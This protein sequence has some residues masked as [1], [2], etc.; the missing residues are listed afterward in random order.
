LFVPL[1]LCD[2]VR[3]TPRSA[4]GIELRVSGEAS[5]ADP[6]NLAW[7]AA[8]AF[9]AEPA[10]AGGVELELEKRIP[11]P[12]GLGGGSS[13]AGAVLRGLSRLQPSAVSP[14]RLAELAMGLGADVPFFLDPRP[15][16][17]EGI[18]EQIEP[19][20]GMPILWLALA[21]PGRPLATPDVF[22]GFDADDSLTGSGP[23]PTIRRLLALR[24]SDMRIEG[25]DE[26]DRAGW[27][28][29]LANDL[30]P[31]AGRLCPEVVEMRKEFE[32][33]QA[34]AVG[35]SGSGPTVYGVFR[36]AATAQDAADQLSG[37]LG[38]RTWVARTTP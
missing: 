15:A 5:P 6:T 8:D 19:L 7:R 25:L 23:R 18:G 36:E 11:S 34:L 17:V 14:S 1:S 4:R 38:F 31:V 29:L 30:E 20:T 9:L 12:G 32:K 33:T 28:A 3:L 37:R 21:H 27:Q 35:M 10:A 2:R 22:A 16:L 13:D 24:G 26:L